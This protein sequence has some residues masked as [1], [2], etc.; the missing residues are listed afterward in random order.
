MATIL[1]GKKTAEEI[2]GEI[3][4]QVKQIKAQGGK[5]PHLAAIL[6]GNDGASETYVNNK[7]RAC[8]KV[9]F[10]SSLLRFDENISEEE[11]LTVV[12][13]V[14]ANDD[15]DGLIVQLPLPQHISVEKVTDRIRPEK[16]VDGF[17]PENV[18][19]MAKNLPAYIAA[20]PYG[21]LQL[22]KRYQIETKGK[23]CVVVGRSHIVGS[24]MSILMAGSGYPGDATVTL[25]HRYTENL[26]EFTKRADILIVAVGIPGFVTAD[27][28]KEGVII[29]DVGITRVE[30]ASKKSGYRLKGDVDYEQVYPKSSFITP[31]PGGV[32]PM[33]IASLLWNTL[34][35][36]QDAVYSGIEVE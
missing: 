2:K 34:L 35:A 3:E 11:L 12:E 32:G 4:E 33:T 17:H 16:D 22:L 14:N 1:D 7:V 5:V 8:E 25:C 20:T 18:G 9:G 26:E 10:E 27:M 30:D 36:A 19:R 29:I 23:H 13:E 15:I 24:P 31:V 21:I 6:V 28:V